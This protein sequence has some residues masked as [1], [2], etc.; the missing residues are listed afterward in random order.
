M[1]N[2]GVNIREWD[3]IWDNLEQVTDMADAGPV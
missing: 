2:G 1:T 3:K